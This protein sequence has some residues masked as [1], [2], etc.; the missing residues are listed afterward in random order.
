[1]CHYLCSCSQYAADIEEMIKSYTT[2][3]TIYK[4]QNQSPDALRVAQKMNEMELIEEIIKE[5][6]YQFVQKQMVYMLGR[7]RNLYESEYD[8]LN[9]IISQDR[10]GENFK[11]LARDLDQMEPKHPDQIFKTHLEDR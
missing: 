7:Q 8:E 10:L 1:M 3:Y 11:L 4:T 6:K 2:A 5:S 9:Q